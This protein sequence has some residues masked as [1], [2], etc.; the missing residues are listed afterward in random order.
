MEIKEGMY[1]RTNYGIAKITGIEIEREVYSLDKPIVWDNME[2]WEDCCTIR[3]IVGEPSYDIAELIAIGDYVNGK[4]V[5]HKYY[6]KGDTIFCIKLF[7]GKML[8]STKR[9][10]SVLTKE[11]FEHIMYEV[12]HEN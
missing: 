4:P 12:N 11:Q 8:H 10:E 6:I 3:D 9:I 1:V 7:G 5:V 2:G